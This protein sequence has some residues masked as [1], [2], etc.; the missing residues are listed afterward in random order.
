MSDLPNWALADNPA[1]TGRTATPGRPYWRNHHT[2]A[3]GLTATDIAEQL[4]T[5]GDDEAHEQHDAHPDTE[6]S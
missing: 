4:A 6:E 5:L 3:L 2:S 1:P